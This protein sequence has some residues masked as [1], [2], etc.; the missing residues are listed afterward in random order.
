MIVERGQL[1][2]GFKG[3]KNEKTIFEFQNGNKWK[4]AEFKQ[5]YYYSFM[6]NAKVIQDGGRFLLEIDGMKDSVE[7]S[8]V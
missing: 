7:V 4:Q 2:G 6:P 3:F 1:K 5:N 8:R